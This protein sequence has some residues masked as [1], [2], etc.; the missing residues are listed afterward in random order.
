MI[1]THLSACGLLLVL[2]AVVHGG[3]QVGVME[4]L[5]VFS[6]GADIY[7]SVSRFKCLSLNLEGD[8]R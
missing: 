4:Y 7:R 2:L 3:I 1:T 6:K 8:A 5:V